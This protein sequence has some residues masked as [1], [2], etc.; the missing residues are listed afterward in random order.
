MGGDQC[1]LQ[2]RD[3][4]S[5]VSSSLHSP[6]SSLLTREGPQKPVEGDALTNL[7]GSAGRAGATSGQCVVGWILGLASSSGF[8]VWPV[9]LVMELGGSPGAGKPTAGQN[10]FSED[11]ILLSVN[12]GEC[13]VGLL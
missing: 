5:G 9:A 13:M 8:L 11:A 12:Q 7:K 6:G 2:C 3:H 10:L 1:T 4:L